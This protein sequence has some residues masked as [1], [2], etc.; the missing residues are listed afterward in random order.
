M[1]RLIAPTVALVVV[2]AGAVHWL[3]PHLTVQ[4]PVVTS[5]PSLQG[6]SSL[7]EVKLRSGQRACIAPLPLDASVRDVQ[8][9]V[10]GHGSESAPIAIELSG[11]GYTGRAR[12]DNYVVSA[13][14]LVQAQFDR[15]PSRSTDGT[16]C[17]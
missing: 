16:M 7:A 5:T 8:M 3:V 4:R 14:T 12:F 17:L 11:P 10:H 13:A 9:L 2:F 1:P 6:Q 15:T